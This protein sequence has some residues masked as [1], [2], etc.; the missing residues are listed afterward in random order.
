[1]A[2]KRIVVISGLAGAGKSTA[3]RALEDL[4][5]F[6]VDNLPPQLI[7]TLINLSDSSGGELRRIALVCDAREA[8]F[9]KDFG[10][11]WDRLQHSGH[12]M[13]LLFLDCVDDVL[14]RR[15]KETRRRHPL[16]EEGEGISEGIAR[17]RQ[18]TSDMHHRADEVIQ[19][20]DLSVHDLKRLIQDRFGTAESPRGVL[21]IMSFGFKHGLPPELDICFDARFLPN[22]F[23]VEELRARTGREKDV[24][25][26]VLAQDGAGEFLKKMED[27]IVFLTPRFQHEGK[28]YVTVAIGC[29]GGKHRSVAL[30]AALE[31]RLSASGQDVRLM[32]RD[33][34][35]G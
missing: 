34:E 32:H 11:T 23:F 9:L 5:F 30:A 25:D 3:A 8:S 7:E 24:S 4:G 17:E 6:V 35:K 33:V 20:Q 13:A 1:M 12:E 10:P 28:A 18:L 29:T 31:A 2:H 22:P 21:T 15:F 14:V 27:L 26:F 19:T 16:A